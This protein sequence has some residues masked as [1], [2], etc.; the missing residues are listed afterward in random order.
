MESLFLLL[1]REGIYTVISDLFAIADELQRYYSLKYLDYA[2]V[3]N[4]LQNRVQPQ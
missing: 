3:A 4:V 2:G 1:L